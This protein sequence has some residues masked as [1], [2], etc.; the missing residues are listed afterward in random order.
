MVDVAVGKN[1]VIDGGG[2]DA[3]FVH[4]RFV[5]VFVA[6][7][8]GIDH[9]ATLVLFYHIDVCRLDIESNNTPR[10]RILND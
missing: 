3:C 1:R 10:I 5:A 6:R 8:T 2:I 9:E 4:Q 7:V